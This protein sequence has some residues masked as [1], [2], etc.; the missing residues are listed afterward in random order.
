MYDDRSQF[1]LF[2]DP[3]SLAESVARWIAG[4]IGKSRGRK[5]ICLSGGSTPKLLYAALAA[6]PV[7]EAMAWDDIHWF[8]GDERFVPHDHADSNYLMARKA[9]FDVSPVAA[10]QV[11][12]VRT[13]LGT[14]ELAAQAYEDELKRFYGR[15][16]LSVDDPLFDIMLLGVGDDGHTA[17]LFPGTAALAERDRWVVSVTGARP[18]PRITL[19]FPALQSSRYVAFLVCGA[20]KKKIVSAIC[21]GEDYPAGHVRP[22]G[23]LHWFLDRLA[24]PLGV[25]EQVSH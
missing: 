4:I 19:T 6:S 9:L 8:W 7:R 18:E 17:S 21:Q 3:A 23:E 12:P 11:H 22:S 5:A 1:H 14:P 10:S 2:E 16:R 24:S 13:G 25:G 20:S 15:N